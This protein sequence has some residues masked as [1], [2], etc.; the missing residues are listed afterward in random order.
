MTG[1]NVSL[2]FLSFLDNPIAYRALVA[3]V[4]DTYLEEAL[5]ISG[6]RYQITLFV[7]LLE[8]FLGRAIVLQ[9]EDIH[10]IGHVHHSISPAYRTIL[11]DPHVGSHKIEDEIEDC[12][13]VTLVLIGQ[14]IG[15]AGEIS[16]QAY[17]CSLQVIIVE[18]F[19]EIT[20]QTAIV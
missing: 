8:G 15:D 19:E 11:F 3:V 5:A 14:A 4:I 7:Y 16:L 12:L 17:H 6:I 20:H 2:S 1:I 9:L 18:L 10:R 13:E